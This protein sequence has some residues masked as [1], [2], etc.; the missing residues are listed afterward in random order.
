MEACLVRANRSGAVFTLCSHACRGVG[1]ARGRVLQYGRSGECSE[2]ERASASSGGRRVMGGSALTGAIDLRQQLSLPRR[3][4]SQRPAR[5]RDASHT[6]LPH[7]YRPLH[8]AR[9]ACLTQHPFIPS[10]TSP[11]YCHC[12]CLSPPPPATVPI[13]P[14][15]PI[16]LHAEEVFK[17]SVTLSHSYSH[18][19]SVRNQEVTP[20]GHSDSMQEGQAWQ[21]LSPH[22]SVPSRTFLPG[23]HDSLTRAITLTRACRQ[24]ITTIA[25]HPPSSVST[26]QLAHP[27]ALKKS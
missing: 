20:H 8:A 2:G 6:P 16:P 13:S 9:C 23:L 24:A 25:H 1:A 4:G 17:R 5:G 11:S 3:R 18:A 27:H 12:A 19:K 15:T 26:F 10:P 14:S 7:H 21:L 22:L